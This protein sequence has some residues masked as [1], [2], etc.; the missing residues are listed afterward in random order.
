MKDKLKR[1]TR[2]MSVALVRVQLTLVLSHDSMQEDK[3]MHLRAPT[4]PVTTFEKC[5]DMESISIY[6]WL[7]AVVSGYMQSVTLMP[8]SR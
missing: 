7:H 2:R 1:H 6:K 4:C 5:L 8:T 3:T